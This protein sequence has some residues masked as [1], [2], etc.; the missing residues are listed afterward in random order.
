[1]PVAYAKIIYEIY[2]LFVILKLRFS[3]IFLFLDSAYGIMVKNAIK[4]V[5]IFRYIQTRIQ[6]LCSDFQVF[7]LSCTL[8]T[9]QKYIQ[10]MS[11]GLKRSQYIL[12]MKYRYI[13]HFI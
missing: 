12:T 10:R 3:C 4:N 7:Q 1:M 6:L 11:K 5:F 13:H 8:S 2:F 9:R